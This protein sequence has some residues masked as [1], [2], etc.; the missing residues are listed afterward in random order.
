MVGRIRLDL[1][2]LRLFLSLA[3]TRHF[4]RTSEHLHMSLSSASRTLQK[5]EGAVGQR[6][7][8]RNNRGV[9][10][11]A[12]GTAFLGYARETVNGWDTLVGGFRGEEALVGEISLYS[13]VT[14]THAIISP[15]IEQFRRQYPG[16][17]LKLH[18]GDQAQAIDRIDRGS[19][20]LAIA[21]HSAALSPELQFAVLEY[22]PLQL[23]APLVNCA[24]SKSLIGLEYIDASVNWM[25]LPLIVAERGLARERLL[26]WLAEHGNEVDIYAQVSG[27]E[28]IVSMVALGL[29]VGVVPA[30]VIE[31]SPHR[32]NVRVLG[33]EPALEDFAVG[34]CARKSRLESPLVAA[35]WECARASYPRGF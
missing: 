11:T 30:L 31:N 9:S 12:A 24:A 16:I 7:F 33:M 3:E 10:L 14:A 34:I 6:L 23:I 27:H 4:G 29:G 20:D 1:R 35:F 18:T 15:I 32:E 28:A 2:S 21:A 13:S 17:D 26:A 25:D 5:L 22:S 19:E 8:D